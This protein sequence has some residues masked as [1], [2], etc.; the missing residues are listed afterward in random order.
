MAARA[1]SPRL[2]LVTGANR[3]IGFEACRQLAQHGLRVL[4]TARDEGRGRR[5]AEGLRKEGWDVHFHRLNVTDTASI[6]TALAFAEGE[7]GGVDVLVNN[8]GVYLDEGVPGLS[9][10]L[11]TVRRTMD[12]NSYGPL[13]LCQAVIP[14]MRRR[15]YG[16]IVNVSSGLGAL[17]SMGGGT[18]AYRLSK[19]SLNALTVI[20]AD[21]VR[22]SGI[23]IN[24]MCPGWV[25]T[26]MG[27]RNAPRSVEQ[28]AETVVFLATL[29]D[30]GPSGVFFRDRNPIPW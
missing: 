16:R 10:D 17:A 18:L 5:A 22:G 21:E 8:A 23:L 11:E 9:I 13:R 26:E 20:L 19:V 25:R 29:P 7:L 6:E 3:G 4:L 27:G 24:A 30:G 12:V 2:A 1:Q 28:G 15:R 14:R